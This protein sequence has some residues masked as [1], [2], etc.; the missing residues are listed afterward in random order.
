MGEID[1]DR[2]VN[3]DSRILYPSYVKGHTLFTKEDCIFG[4]P[5]LHKILGTYCLSHYAYRFY[6]SVNY[7]F[8][9]KEDPW[10]SGF[11]SSIGSLLC[12]WVHA[13]LSFSSL[14][15]HVLKRQTVKPMIWEEFRAHNILFAMRSIICFTVT[16]LAYN[17]EY[18]ENIQKILKVSIVLMTMKGADI[19]TEKL[20]DNNQQTTTR[21]LKYWEGVSEPVQKS[22]K[23]YYMIAQYQATISCLSQY[24]F[25][26]SFSVMFPIQ[27]SSFLLTLCRKGYIGTSQYHGLYTISLM[28]P[29]FITWNN[30]YFYHIHIPAITLTLLKRYF[31]MNKFVLWTPLLL[32]YIMYA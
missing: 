24:Y 27:I 2:I 30:E 11:H 28:I 22:F 12:V 18:V 6:L 25:F 8:T 20:R 7:Q 29:A 26:P 19:I 14:V 3:E 32:I 5:H 9:M 31:N 17:S 10:Q 4:V 1:Q 15:F 23:F 13:L 16:W 21:T